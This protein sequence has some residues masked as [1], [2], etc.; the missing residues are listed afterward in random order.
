MCN[1]LWFFQQTIINLAASQV[2]KEAT[3]VSFV[4][5]VVDGSVAV[6]FRTDDKIFLG[7]YNVCTGAKLS[8]TVLGDEPDGMASVPLS[9]KPCLALSFG[10][11]IYTIT[12]ESTAM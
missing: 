11:V 6:C 10:Y 5:G 9:G 1:K 2:L 12:M 8:G 4:S 3:D 7:R